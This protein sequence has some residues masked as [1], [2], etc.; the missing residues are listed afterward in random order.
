MYEQQELGFNYRMT[1]IHAA[2]G[3]S[4]LKR[5]DQIVETRN[6][7]FNYYQELLSDLP[8]CLLKIPK[9]V[10]SSLHLA[11]IRLK[12]KDPKVHKD[13]FIRLRE[14]KI[15]VAVTLQSGSP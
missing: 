13:L 6:K 10:I 1:D 2:L 8:L 14:S 3:L 4:Q 15:G 11:V 5:L 9:G 12:D 7:I